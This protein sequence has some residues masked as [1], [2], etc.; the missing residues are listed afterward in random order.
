MVLP[1]AHFAPGPRVTRRGVSTSKQ[2][3]SSHLTGSL[4]TRRGR[5]PAVGRPL[6]S[7][8][9]DIGK[10]LSGGD[11]DCGC[12]HSGDAPAADHPCPLRE[13]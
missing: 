8:S 9:A 7:E 13:L 5:G 6:G 1:F 11:P 3:L 12:R 10:H 4:S 2:L